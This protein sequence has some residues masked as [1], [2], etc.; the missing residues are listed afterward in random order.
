[1]MEQ[2]TK[3]VVSAKNRLYRDQDL[4]F[5]EEFQK[6]RHDEITERVNEIRRI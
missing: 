4:K 2:R 5:N 6:R 3:S 1:M